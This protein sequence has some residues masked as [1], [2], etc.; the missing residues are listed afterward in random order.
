MYIMTK[1]RALKT[2]KAAKGNVDFWFLH[3]M[4]DTIPENKYNDAVECIYYIGRA[5]VVA[6][7]LEIDF[8]ENTKIERNALENIKR[9][10]QREFIYKLGGNR[11]ESKEI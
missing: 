1:E 9:Y 10:L 4:R 11:N 5:M 6:E 7:I 3:T 2:W 8:L